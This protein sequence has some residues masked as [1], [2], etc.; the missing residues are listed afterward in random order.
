MAIKRNKGGPIQRDIL[1]SDE[2]REVTNV[3]FEL[4]LAYGFR[5]GSPEEALFIAVQQLRRRSEGGLYLVTRR[6]PTGSDFY[7]LS[8]VALN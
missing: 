3:A 5:G 7:L 1:G 2:V 8:R 4:W 6:A